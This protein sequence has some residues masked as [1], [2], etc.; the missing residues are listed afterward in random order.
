KTK[1][2]MLSHKNVF[3]PK[4]DTKKDEQKIE[5]QIAILRKN[6]CNFQALITLIDHYK[7][8]LKQDKMRASIYK[9]TVGCTMY[10]FVQ[11]CLKEITTLSALEIPHFEKIDIWV[12]NLHAVLEHKNL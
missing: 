10:E 4:V 1:L 2:P 6:P 9:L 11:R 12:K 7:I 8:I 3:S 5:Q